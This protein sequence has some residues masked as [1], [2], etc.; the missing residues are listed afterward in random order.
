MRVIAGVTGFGQRRPL[1]STR[2][3]R[4]ETPGRRNDTDPQQP[5]SVNRMSGRTPDQLSSKHH[6]TAANILDNNVEDGNTMGGAISFLGMMMPAHYLIL[7]SVM[8]PLID[9]TDNVWVPVIYAI[10]MLIASAAC[11]TLLYCVPHRRK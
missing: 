2:A 9:A 6:W 11:L 3:L 7:S 4:Q 1:C 10:V 8:G 5:G